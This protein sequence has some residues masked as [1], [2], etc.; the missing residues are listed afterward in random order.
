[1]ELD[2][3]E[4]IPRKRNRKVGGGRKQVIVKQA[5]INASLSESALIN[6]GECLILK[7]KQW[8]ECR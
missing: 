4:S 7:V 5:D 2:G 1:M 6:F 3:E 8:V